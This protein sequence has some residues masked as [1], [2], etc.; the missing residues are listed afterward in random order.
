MP[1]VRVRYRYPV[2]TMA[3]NLLGSL[4]PEIVA[5]ALTCDNPE[6]SLTAEDVEVE[7]GVMPAG[8][9]TKYH[10]HVEVEANAYPERI[11]VLERRTHLITSRIRQFFNDPENRV[12]SG[13]RPKGWVWV[14]L[15]PAHWVEI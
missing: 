15:F 12:L 1:I 2:T 3:A 8:L 5:E 14:K 11:D 13:L 6:G 9:N 7:V 4:L 10:L